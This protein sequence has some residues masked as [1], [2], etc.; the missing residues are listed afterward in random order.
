VAA[1]ACQVCFLTRTSSVIRSRAQKSL[2]SRCIIVPNSLDFSAFYLGRH[3]EQASSPTMK[4]S[5]ALAAALFL[6]V[7]VN[8]QGNPEF[9]EQPST[10]P[11]P[12]PVQASVLA[13]TPAFTTESTVSK[14]DVAPIIVGVG[15]TSTPLSPSNPG[16]PSSHVIPDTAPA[17]DTKTVCCM[18]TL[19]PVSSTS[20][21]IPA[22]TSTE[23]EATSS[24]SYSVP[25]TVPA[26]ISTPPSASASSYSVPASTSTTESASSA[27]PTVPASTTTTGPTSF[28]SPSVMA[29]TTT[30]G[31]PS[32]TASTYSTAPPASTTQID[33]RGVLITVH[34]F[35]D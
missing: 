26:S 22:S 7:P 16:N 8:A 19:P 14:T 24:T 3:T 9:P 25:A 20:Y 15:S 5:F 31:G 13:S 29:S 27:Y 11:T 32:P 34:A 18:S 28:S 12:P 23:L 6:P 33:V 4:L 35:A 1:V 30:E 2:T 21:S 10:T 17:T